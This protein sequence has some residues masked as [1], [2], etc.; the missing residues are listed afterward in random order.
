M[1]SS[2]VPSYPAL[3]CKADAGS[4]FRYES[5]GKRKSDEEIAGDIKID[6]IIHHEYNIHILF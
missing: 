5:D 1:R 3:L 6:K 2:H 4:L